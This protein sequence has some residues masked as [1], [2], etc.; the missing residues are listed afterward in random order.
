MMDLE[1]AALRADDAHT[2]NAVIWRLLER[3]IKDSASPLRLPVISTSGTD[4]PQGRLVVLRE[5]NVA[6]RTLT[7]FTDLRSPKVAALRAEP[8]LAWTFWDMRYKLQIRAHT[9][10]TLH[11]RDERTHTL[12]MHVPEHARRDYTALTAPGEVLDV[13][14]FDPERFE[15]HFCVIDATVQHLDVL[16]LRS[17]DHGGHKRL[18]I[19]YQTQQ[20]FWLVP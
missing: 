18:R 2:W 5:V 15:Q 13:H 16:A 10:A 9:L 17:R 12:A 19:D 4:G 11:V 3:S 6:Q 1:D 20:H 8:R 14:D 7:L